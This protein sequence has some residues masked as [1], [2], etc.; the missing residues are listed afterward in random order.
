MFGP[1]PMALI[2]GKVTSRMISGW[3]PKFEHVSTFD[4]GL[5]D[6]PD[7]DFED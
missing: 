3:L 2:A 7:D 1:L 6:A 4:R 5:L